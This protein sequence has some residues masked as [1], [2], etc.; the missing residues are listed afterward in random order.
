MRKN[1]ILLKKL[2]LITLVLLCTKLSVQSDFKIQENK[3]TS[4]LTRSEVENYQDWID[5]KNSFLR[6]ESILNEL[7]KSFQPQSNEYYEGILKFDLIFIILGGIISFLFLLYLILRVGFNKCV[8]PISIK[9]INKG[10]KIITWI[11]L[12]GSLISFVAIYSFIIIP[13]ISLG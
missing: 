2:T 1:T 7:P 9:Q 12:V 6:S 4:E 11:I 10:Y 8:G 13:S 5:F 3:Y